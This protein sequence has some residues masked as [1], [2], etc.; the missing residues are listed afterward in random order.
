MG[1]GLLQGQAGLRAQKPLTAEVAVRSC[2]VTSLKPTDVTETRYT[3]T[4]MHTHAVISITSV[5]G[6]LD[7]S[8]VDAHMTQE[9][10]WAKQLYPGLWGRA[11]GGSPCAGHTP[12]PLLVG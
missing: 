9:C 6:T 8:R 10:N 12:G 2:L 3:H 11:W 1:A 4:H 7:A 5:C